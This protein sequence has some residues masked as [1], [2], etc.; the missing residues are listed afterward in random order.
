[1]TSPTGTSSPNSSTTLFSTFTMLLPMDPGFL[2]RSSGLKHVTGEASDKPNPTETMT[3]KYCS[4]FFRRA[5]GIADP[6]DIQKRIS[7]KSSLVPFLLC[8]KQLYIVGTPA[9]IVA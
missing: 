5:T 8:T 1:P 6:P 9:K 3:S 4:K 2:G 7:L